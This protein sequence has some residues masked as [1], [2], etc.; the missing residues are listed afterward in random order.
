MFT[1]IGLGLLLIWGMLNLIFTGLAARIELAGEKGAKEYYWE[2][3]LFS[4]F[5]F[6]PSSLLCFVFNYIHTG[7]LF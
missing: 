1:T 7:R 2:R 5:V 3:F 6:L 4:S